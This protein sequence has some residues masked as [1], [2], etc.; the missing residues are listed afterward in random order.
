MQQHLTNY[1]IFNL[2]YH[3]SC[4]ILIFFCVETGR[5]FFIPLIVFSYFHSKLYL[6]EQHIV[7]I[8][9]YACV[10]VCAMETMY[11]A[12]FHNNKINNPDTTDI[13]IWI[14]ICVLYYASI[15]S[16]RVYIYYTKTYL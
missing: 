14:F 6:P 15:C 13:P 3:L 16:R 11:G 1:Y 4:F 5:L 2:F 9:I 12:Y 10:R 7:Y 8:P